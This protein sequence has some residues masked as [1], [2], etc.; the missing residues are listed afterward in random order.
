[1]GRQFWCWVVLVTVAVSTLCPLQPSHSAAAKE[2]ADDTSPLINTSPRA[3]VD[4]TASSQGISWNNLTNRFHTPPRLAEASLAYDSQNGYELMFGGVTLG[5]NATPISISNSTYLM[6]PDGTWFEVNTPHAPP[7]RGG[8][9]LEY[10]STIGDFV[11]FGG[12]NYTNILGDMWAFNMTTLSWVNV[13]A[14]SSGPSPRAF[15]A[16]APIP[17]NTGFYMFGGGRLRISAHDITDVVMFNDTWMYTPS[18]GWKNYTSTVA[19]PPRFGAVMVALPVNSLFP[20]DNFVMTGGYGEGPILPLMQTDTWIFSSILREWEPENQTLGSPTSGFGCGI[21]DPGGGGVLYFDGGNLTGTG[22]TTWRWTPSKGWTELSPVGAMRAPALTGAVCAPNAAQQGVVVYGGTYTYFTGT[23]VN[24]TTFNTT[25]V[26]RDTGWKVDISGTAPLLSGTAFNV[27]AEAINQ[28]GSLEGVNTHLALSDATGT[29]SPAE[30]PLVNGSGTVKAVVWKP[31]SPDVVSVCQWGICVQLTAVVQ[32]P[33]DRLVLSTIPG[34]LRAGSETNVTIQVENSAGSLATWW[35]GSASVGVVPLGPSFSVPLIN[36]TG[37]APMRILKAGAYS[38]MVL[39]SGLAGAMDNFTVIPAAFDILEISLSLTKEPVGGNQIVSFQTSDIFGNL[40][41][42][43]VVNVTD[44]LGDMLPTQ[45]GLIGGEGEV[46]IHLGNRTGGDRIEANAAGIYNISETFEVESNPTPPQTTSTPTPWWE[47]PMWI[48]VIVAVVA[49][50]LIIVYLLRR[51]RAK[52]KEEG[53][54][55]KG[56]R[57][58]Y[59]ALLPFSREDKE[60]DKEE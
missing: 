37:V 12:S 30:I 58:P 26:V 21:Y 28:S 34:P 13:T 1:M 23:A 55:K 54:D 18:G 49:A 29:I 44:T 11:L 48:G 10:I 2:K 51:R 27:T 35:N 31:A 57:I 3:T 6:A 19:P 52:G 43:S 36:G 16:A 39:A 56:E 59:L 25:Y 53:A 17:G 42:I 20:G 14:L 47:S 50:A 32:S 33:P 22:N 38:V 46:S 60:E 8:A 5:Q 15:A 41:N 7:S 9:L 40:I 24:V 4:I 45:V